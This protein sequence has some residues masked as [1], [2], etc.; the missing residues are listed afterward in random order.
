MCDVMAGVGPFAIP[1]GKKRV[2]VSANDLNPDCKAALSYGIRKNKVEQFV[3]VECMDGREFI[4]RA[5]AE[6]ARGDRRIT[7]TQPTKTP[8]QRRRSSPTSEAPGRKLNALKSFQHYVMNLPASAVEFLDAFKDTYAGRSQEFAPFSETKL[9]M[10]HV[11][12]FSEQR[13]TEEEDLE[14]VCELL[15]KHLGHRIFPD[16]PDT[17]I[18]FVRR[19][20]PKKKMF[21]ASFRLPPGIAFAE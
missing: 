7:I 6:L 18:Y 16:T 15:S 5:T 4:R 10:I 13:E 8:R 11:Y 20:S 17:E 9:P 1:A 2:F 3:S 14:S 21:C 12:C 19:V